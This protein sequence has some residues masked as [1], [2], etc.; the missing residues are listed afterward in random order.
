MQ[1]TLY[2]PVALSYFS[3]SE[4]TDNGFLPFL[5][6]EYKAI[7]LAWEQH[8][9]QTGSDRYF[10]VYFPARGSADGEKVE[11]DVRNYKDRIILF[12]FS[13]HASSKK[14]LFKD[15]ASHALG[16]AGLLGGSP[17]LKLVVLNGCATYDQVNLLFEN[18]V[19]VVI[20][21][22]G[23]VNDGI[24]RK[25]AETFY[26][27]LSTT[28]FTIQRAYKHALSEL[29]R[30]HDSL[31]SISTEPIIWRGLI[32][33]REDDRDRWELYVRE[34]CKELIA[35]PNWWR[36]GDLPSSYER[37][38]TLLSS[39]GVDNPNVFIGRRDELEN[40]RERLVKGGKLMLINAEGGI[41]KTT[42]AARYWNESLYEYQHNAWLFCENGIV[43][44]LKELAPKLNVDLAGL[45]EA[46]QLAALRHALSQ[47]HDDFLLVLDNAN[48]ADEIR[49]F[50]QEFAGFHWHVLITSRCQGVLDKEQELTI[51]HLPPPLAKALFEKY[52]TEDTPNFDALLDRLLEAIRYHTLLV[53]L[54]AKNLKEASELGMTL[55]NFLQKLETGGLYLGVE[56]SF[57]I[58]TS[59]TGSVQKAA[60][61]TDD[62]LDILYDFS[63]LT[64]DQRY[65]LINLA[66]LPAESYTMLLLT[67]VMEPAD[68]KA[69]HSTL[70]S[71]YQK[72]WVG[73]TDKTYRLS[74]VVQELVLKKNEG[75]RWEDA[76]SL[77]E[78]FAN[79]LK[80][81][82]DKDNTFTKFKW[83][84]L[85]LS[86]LKSVEASND[87]VF[88]TFLN[89]L[90]FVLQDL[91]GEANLGRASALLHKAL[92]SN[93]ANFGESSPALIN[94]GWNLFNLCLETNSF[95]E[96]ANHLLLIYPISEKHLPETHP[97]KP[98]LREYYRQFKE[99]GY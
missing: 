53:E 57:S 58:Q 54:F 41:G 37:P 50:K 66:L 18:K 32:T 42:L 14:L 90:A 80:H 6:A 46:Q 31:G 60:A 43:N 63:T 16:I 82:P 55:A 97:L 13:G 99:A 52:Y 47:V 2:R 23:K 28:A 40:I 87:P 85:A 1:N 36:I 84:P 72:G 95:Q 67:E 9:I 70:K 25:F 88:S 61:T 4:D 65:L 98:M 29:Q 89:N 96:A 15:G 45:E 62:I 11:E 27:A 17:N 19:K 21:T 74:P 71:L 39:K 56:D 78:G 22:K 3:Q 33:G 10:E 51:T 30:K 91:G 38:A 76:K 81:E 24:A 7:D 93:I 49:A 26:K 44:A 92:E 8:Q 68:M 35:D 73:G 79:L 12:H 86:L 75:T 34:E 69:F 77:V 48:D 64:E 5:E 83:V 59:Y 94:A 20:A